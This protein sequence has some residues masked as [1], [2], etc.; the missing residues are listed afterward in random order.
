MTG[1]L[2]GTVASLRLIELVEVPFL[3]E[4]RNAEWVLITA[5]AQGGVILNCE[6]RLLLPDVRVEVVVAPSIPNHKLITA[7]RSVILVI[8]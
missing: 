3:W 8:Q 4:Y 7:M 6:P 5:A 1:E 2:V